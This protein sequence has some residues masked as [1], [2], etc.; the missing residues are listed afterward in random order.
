MVMTILVVVAT[1]NHW[2]LDGIVA[3]IVLVGCAWAR[4][5][6]STG[7]H[8]IVAKWRPAAPAP[9]AAPEPALP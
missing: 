2:W 9:A 7:W 6:L 5:G 3:V 1:A 8:A 4:H